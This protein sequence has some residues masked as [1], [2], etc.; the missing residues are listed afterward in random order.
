MRQWIMIIVTK[1]YVFKSLSIFKSFKSVKCDYKRSNTH[2]HT[3]IHTHTHS[4]L[5]LSLSLSSVVMNTDH[6]RS[7]EIIF[8]SQ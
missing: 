5:S 4:S 7:I 3:H 1:M 8:P 6:L 2:T